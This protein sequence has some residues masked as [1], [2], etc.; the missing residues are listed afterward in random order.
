MP[1][2]AAPRRGSYHKSVNGHAFK[3][4]CDVITD[5]IGQ[6]SPQGK[7]AFTFQEVRNLASARLTRTHGS[8][9]P[10]I[11]WKLPPISWDWVER[12]FQDTMGIDF[13]PLSEYYFSKL[14]VKTKSRTYDILMGEPMNTVAFRSISCCP[15]I[16][17][18]VGFLV[19][20]AII[21]P[22]D[23]VFPL[24]WLEWRKAVG[25]GHIR[26]AMVRLDRS[27][28]NKTLTQAEADLVLDKKNFTP[29]RRML[30]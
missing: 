29:L 9:T 1:P 5:M 23:Q 25:A 14:N 17:C 18:S 26:S 22:I 3:A 28:A 27:V 13:I 20:S 11:P 12:Y 2:A 15:P 30:K 21:H 8:L 16:S 19:N 6:P 7:P 10:G 4:V 24:T